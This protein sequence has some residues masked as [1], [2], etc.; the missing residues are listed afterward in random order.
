MSE[1]EEDKGELA[2]KIEKEDAYNDFLMAYKI[3]ELDKLVEHK[4]F[5]EGSILDEDQ[6]V[7]MY[8]DKDQKKFL[9][10]TR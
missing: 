9:E 2:P 10:S 6:Y 1:D 4:S 7:D 3:K 5:N 8:L